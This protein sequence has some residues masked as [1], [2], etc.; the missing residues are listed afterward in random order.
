[1]MSLELLGSRAI[2]PYFGSS[3]YMWTLVLGGTMTALAIGYY[4]CGIV[5][6]SAAYASLLNNLFILAATA[7]LM[8][9]FIYKRGSEG[10]RVHRPRYIT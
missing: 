4:L 5:A 8:L 2:A 10:A 7:F 1:V 9:S 6:Q 3:I